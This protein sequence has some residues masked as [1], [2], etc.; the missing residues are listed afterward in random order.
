MAQTLSKTARAKLK[1]MNASEKKSIISSV[2]KML[3]ASL[4]GPKY[5]MYLFRMYK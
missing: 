5:A 2:K 3:D 1:G 4:I